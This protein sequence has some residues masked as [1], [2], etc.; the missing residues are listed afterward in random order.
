MDKGWNP[1]PATHLGLSGET[2]SG[3]MFSWAFHHIYALV[4]TLNSICDQPG[5]F[6]SWKNLLQDSTPKGRG[7]WI[8]VHPSSAILK[9]HL[10]L[11]TSIWKN[12][13]KNMRH[14]NLLIQYCIAFLIN[15]KCSVYNIWLCSESL[16]QTC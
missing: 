15:F 13:E 1:S 14:I 11:D 9:L 7:A 12:N 2:S 8:P 4:S 16:L 6:F 5:L 3:T 10:I